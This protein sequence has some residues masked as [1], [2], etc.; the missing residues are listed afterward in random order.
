MLGARASL[1]RLEPTRGPAIVSVRLAIPDGRGGG[2]SGVLAPTAQPIEIRCV[3]WRSSAQSDFAMIES[4]PPT[5]QSTFA[6][7]S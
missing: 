2:S 7:C 4:P 3:R 5:F 6:R 1:L